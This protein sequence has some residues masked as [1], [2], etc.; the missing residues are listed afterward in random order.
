MAAE[1]KQVTKVQR[2]TVH[3]VSILN[4]LKFSVYISYRLKKMKENKWKAH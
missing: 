3:W 4:V 2:V 1:G